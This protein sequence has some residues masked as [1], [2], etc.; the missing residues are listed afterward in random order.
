MNKI[1]P[2]GNNTKISIR[3]FNDRKVRTIWNEENNK[4]WF[5]V[6]DIVAALSESEDAR[7]YWYVLKNRL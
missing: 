5:S 4:W 3:F 6:V 7:N 2:M 1:E